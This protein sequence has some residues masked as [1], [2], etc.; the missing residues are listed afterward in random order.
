[1]ALT[2]IRLNAE[3]P[4]CLKKGGTT[5]AGRLTFVGASSS[6]LAR[7]L[8]VVLG[9]TS[10]GGSVGNWNGNDSLLSLDIVHVERRSRSGLSNSYGG[11]REMQGL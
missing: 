1:M 11:S 10:S 9:F 8:S 6:V 2:P 5:K 3:S 4:E 7:L